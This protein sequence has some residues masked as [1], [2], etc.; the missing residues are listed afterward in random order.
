MVLAGDSCRHVERKVILQCSWLYCLL[1]PVIKYHKQYFSFSFWFIQWLEYLFTVITPGYKLKG[2]MVREA[3]TFY[4]FGDSVMF[5]RARHTRFNN[6][7]SK[8]LCTLSHSLLW[9][10]SK[11]WSLKIYHYLFY[12]SLLVSD[13]IVKSPLGSILPLSD[14]LWPLPISSTMAHVSTQIKIWPEKMH[15]IKYWGQEV[16]FNKPH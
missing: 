3:C 2:S 6:A 5:F 7:Y 14:D 10:K 1:K 13:A 16:R 8:K 11:G 15:F 12:T 9:L 4:Y